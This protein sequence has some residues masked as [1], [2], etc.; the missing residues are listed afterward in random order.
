MKFNWTLLGLLI[1]SAATSAGI[2]YIVVME[3]MELFGGVK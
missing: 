3:A 1:W 2:I